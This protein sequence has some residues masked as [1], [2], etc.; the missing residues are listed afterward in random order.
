MMTDMNVYSPFYEIRRT[1]VLLRWTF[2]FPLQAKDGSYTEFKFVLWLECL[3]YFVVCLIPAMTWVYWAFV[4]LIVD[5]NL[6]NFITLHMEWFDVISPNKIDQ[7]LMLLLVV[8]GVIMSF[9]YFLLFKLNTQ[10][11]NNFCTEV[12]I[13]KSKMTAISINKEEEE[14]PP[15]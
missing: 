11:I 5:G 6:E 4:L 8:N 1:L 9:S 15:H 13:T 2:G 3:R 10:T 12:T 14:K 7:A